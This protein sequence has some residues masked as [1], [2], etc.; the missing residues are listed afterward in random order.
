[1]FPLPRSSTAQKGG[2]QPTTASGVGHLPV[3][4]TGGLE[5][6]FYTLLSSGQPKQQGSVRPWLYLQNSTKFRSPSKYLNYDSHDRSWCLVT[7]YFHLPTFVSTVYQQTTSYTIQQKCRQ[8]TKVI[9]G[10]GSARRITQP[11]VPV[12][13]TIPETAVV[14]RRQA[15]GYRMNEK[16]IKD[17]LK[18]LG[19]WQVLNHKVHIHV[20]DA[21]SLHKVTCNLTPI[22]FGS[23]NRLINL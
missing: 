21:S 15:T 13:P 12:E 9:T 16:K 3:R 23:A 2:G 1:M 10:D 7:A 6:F 14:P 4:A 18:V 19:T 5:V 8:A 20:F 22:N 11:T 17:H